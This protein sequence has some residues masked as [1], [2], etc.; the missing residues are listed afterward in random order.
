[1][2]SF[3]DEVEQILIPWKNFGY[4]GHQYRPAGR[5]VDN[6]FWA[7]KDKVVQGKHFVRSQ[8]LVRANIHFSA[9]LQ[10]HSALEDGTVSR[11]QTA[12]ENPRY[13]LAQI[14]HYTTRSY[15]EAEQ[16]SLKGR[17][18]GHPAK[19]LFPFSGDKL[20]E[21][22][23]L[24]FDDSITQH[25]AKSQ[26]MLTMVQSLSEQPHRYGYW[27]KNQARAYRG[28]H[29]ALTHYYFAKSLGNHVLGETKT[30]HG[31]KFEVEDNRTPMQRHARSI[32]NFQI[33]RLIRSRLSFQI[34]PIMGRF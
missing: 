34:Q 2:A 16:R 15:Q 19:P 28:S 27:V 29:R 3:P 12:L 8:A 31:T 18:S 32:A 20:R 30:S 11:A 5:T 33:G 1:M 21:G 24:Q 14:N 13:A 22:P 4:S 17:A 23:N 10:G 7:T 25:A 9:T 6:F 26:Q